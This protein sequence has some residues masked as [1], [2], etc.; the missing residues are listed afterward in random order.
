MHC[1]AVVLGTP[2][3]EHVEATINELLSAYDENLEVEEYDEPC[4]CIGEQAEREA[5]KAVQGRSAKLP[6]VSKSSTAISSNGFV[7]LKV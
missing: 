2:D 6:P 1:C 7:S 4:Y 5:H 3:R